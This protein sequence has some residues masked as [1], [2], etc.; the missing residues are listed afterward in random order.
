MCL[1]Q[2]FNVENR[3]ILQGYSHKEIQVYQGYLTSRANDTST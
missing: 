2:R 1:Y 3:T